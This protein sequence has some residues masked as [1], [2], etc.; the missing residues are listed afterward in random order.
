MTMIREV[1]YETGIT[2]T[3]GIGTNLYLA[4]VAMDIVAKHVPADE[5]GVR[6]AELAEK[7]Y[8]ELLWCHK[9]LTDFWR[10]GD[11]IARRLDALGLH[12]MGDVARQSVKD[13]SVLYDALGI[14]AELVI[15][16]AWG[17]E[18][19]EIRTIKSY[20]PETNSISSGQVLMEPYSAVKAR[21]IVRERFSSFMVAVMASVY[22]RPAFLWALKAL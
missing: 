7:S 19:T 12:T 8:R 2:A 1:L 15:D 21:L 6:I 13:E 3:A 10:I 4:K 16:H 14:N 22:D 17:W 5:N 20:R 9:P 18:P 11:G